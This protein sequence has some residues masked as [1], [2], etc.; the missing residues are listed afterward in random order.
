MG[1]IR[2]FGREDE[3]S[4]P[5]SSWLCFNAVV[6]I[7]IK[8]AT[9]VLKKGQSQKQELVVRKA[10]MHQTAKKIEEEAGLI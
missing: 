8:H 7:S 4:Y 5:S 1:L 2:I 6:V 3:G 9:H 10:E